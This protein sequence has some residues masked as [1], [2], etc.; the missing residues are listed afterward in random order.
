MPHL[1]N[2]VMLPDNEF[3]EKILRFVGITFGF[4]ANNAP[5]W[6]QETQK[7]AKAELNC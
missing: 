7:Q 2:I 4:T 6:N 5:S 3:N 1:D